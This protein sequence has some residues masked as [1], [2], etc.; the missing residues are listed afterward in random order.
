MSPE[1]PKYIR[2]QPAPSSRQNAGHARR[3]HDYDQYRVRRFM[4]PPEILGR[5]PMQAP[6]Q[7]PPQP[8]PPP[9]DRL[10]MEDDGTVE[11]AIA[12]WTAARRRKRKLFAVR[13]KKAIR[14]AL[15]S[16]LR[17]RD[18]ASGGPVH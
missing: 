8:P 9:P 2:R 13:L 3:L 14:A 15:P 1:Q 11:G 17:K 7:P 6:A 10:G 18:G 12:A 4:A 16:A 5:A